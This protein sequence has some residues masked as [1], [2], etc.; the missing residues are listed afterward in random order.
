MAVPRGARIVRVPIVIT[1]QQRGEDEGVVKTPA[2][3]QK[4]RVP[5]RLVNRFAKKSFS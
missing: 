3:D 5:R 4:V 2:K 1:S